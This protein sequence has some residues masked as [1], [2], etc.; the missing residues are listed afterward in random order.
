MTDEISSD[1]KH[2]DGTLDTIGVRGRGRPRHK[3][4]ARV[5]AP[6]CT[7]REV[8]LYERDVHLRMPFRFGVVTLTEAPQCFVRVRI[9][10]ADG[11]SQW[12]GVRRAAGAEMVRQ[13]PGALEPGQFRSV[14]AGASRSPQTLISTARHERRSAISPRTMTSRSRPAPPTVSIRWSPITVRRSSTAPFSTRFSWR[15]VVRSM[16]AS[17]DNLAGVDPALLAEPRQ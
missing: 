2:L 1:F 6:L 16:K 15:W 17:A 7:I 10:L 12:G 9:E 13:E 14:A 4:A 5:S 8:R 3:A 11:R